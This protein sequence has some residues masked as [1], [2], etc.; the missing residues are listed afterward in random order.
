MLNIITHIL[1]LFLFY[2]SAAPLSG[3]TCLACLDGDPPAPPELQSGQWSHSWRAVSVGCGAAGDGD[4]D[5]NDGRPD[6][7]PASSLLHPSHLPPG[8]GRR[9][10][11]GVRLDKGGG[12]GRD[13]VN[14]ECG[15]RG[16][17]FHRRCRQTVHCCCA[18][19]HHRCCCLPLPSRCP[20]P[21][22]QSLPLP[23]R[24]PP[25]PLPSSSS[26]LRRRRH[27]PSP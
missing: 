15:E 20:L 4:A 11:C 17:A 18:F 5:N 9:S 7:S 13:K 23:L 14:D 8:I 1:V 6:R 3:T 12:N 24:R 22:L 2:F 19:Q 25:S 21:L 16:A 10:C 27:G 26:P